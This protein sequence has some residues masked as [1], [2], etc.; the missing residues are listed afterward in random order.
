MANPNH[1][2]DDGTIQ[3][4]SSHKDSDW[5]TPEQYVQA[6]GLSSATVSR[7]LADGRLPKYQPGGPRCRVLIPRDALPTAEHPNPI[8]ELPVESSSGSCLSDEKPNNLK[9][10]TRPAGPVPR[11]LRRTKVGESNV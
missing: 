11:W 3:E 6:T 10:S 2:L 7:Y 5:L 1:E 4:E 8:Q 9:E